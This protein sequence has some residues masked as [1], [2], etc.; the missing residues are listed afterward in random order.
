[1][2]SSDVPATVELIKSAPTH[3]DLITACEAYIDDIKNDNNWDFYSNGEFVFLNRIA[4]FCHTVFDVGACIGEWTLKFLELKPDALVH[5]FEP[6]EI[7]QPKLI[8]NL[9]GKAIINGFAIGA[10]R[11]ERTLNV[12]AEA[13]QDH[14]ELASLYK[15][16]AAIGETVEFKTSVLTLLDYCRDNKIE[17]IDLLKIDTEGAE[18]DI[19]TGG[20]Q[21]FAEERIM[22]AQIEYGGTWLGPRRQLRDAFDLMEGL[23]YTM[24]KLM[25]DR[26]MVVD[27]YWP[28]LDNYQ[29]SN[30]LILHNDIVETL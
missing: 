16:D 17:H 19:L 18:M 28:A 26:Y 11:G 7:N 25:Q 10:E 29:Y 15:R 3:P 14:W 4:P 30:W 1:M 20:R 22:A 12:V 8:Q 23:P 6:L 13:G 24:A 9:S 5:C 2:A 21:M 27:K